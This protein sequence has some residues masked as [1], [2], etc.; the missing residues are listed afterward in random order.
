MDLSIIIPAR[1]EIFL[2][3]TIDDILANSEAETEIIVILDGAWSAD[4]L[5]DHPKVTLVYHPESIGQRA[6]VNEGVRMSRAK[7]IMKCDAH[8]TFDKGFD[9]KLM[10]DCEPD[11]TVV[12]R[13]YN[14]HAFDW[15][16][17]DCGRRTYQGPKKCGSCKNVNVDMDIVWKR[18]NNPSDYM[19]FDTDMKF[20][21]FDNNALKPYGEKAKEIY[22]HGK[23]DWAKGE[24]TDQ[25]TCLG[26]C[27]FMHRT[28]YWELGGMDEGH[29]G[30]GQMGV[31]VACKAW[32]S[33]GALKVNKKTWFSHMFRTKDEFS[34]PYPMKHSE[35]EIARKYSRDL[36]KNDKWDKAIYPFSYIIE[37][38]D[39][40]PGW[41]LQME[42]DTDLGNCS[43]SNLDSYSKGIVYYTDNQASEHILMSVRNQLSKICNGHKI[44]SVSLC[45]IDFHD[46]IVLPL[47][48]GILTMFKQILAGL[49]RIDTD[50]V[51]LCEHDIIYHP[52]HFDFVPERD[53]IF[54]YNVNTWKVDA[55]SGQALFYYTKQTSGLCANRE[56]L[57]EHYRKRVERVAKEGRYSRN[58]GFEPGTHSPPRGIDHYKAESWMSEHPNIDIRHKHNLTKTR[59]SR[60]Q[61]RSQ[62]ACTGWTMADEVPSWGK[63]KDR[64]SEFLKEVIK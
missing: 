50:I 6:A 47:E 37:K 29:G 40:L 15:V 24:I 23:R 44:V 60:D 3:K 48:R 63:T 10:A 61:F 42:E 58:M 51:F 54:Y 30:W 39:P 38:F 36:W 14:L 19:W 18:K 34:F 17:K 55:D 12:P 16:C 8:C 4:G 20:R 32:L 22:S 7:Y 45:P 57:L 28:R 59:W 35:Q 64:F 41:D 26:A 27:W 56:L 52:S 43:I 5:K 31:E 9:V 49:E 11:W 13:M 2:A 33:G 46:N 21:Y 53:D 62:K 25:M 1:N